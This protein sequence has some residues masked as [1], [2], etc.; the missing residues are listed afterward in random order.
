MTAVRLPFL[1]C[2]Y[3]ECNED[4]GPGIEGET[5]K[6]LRAKAKGA[7]WS[8]ALGA[9]L[10]ATHTANIGAGRGRVRVV[11]ITRNGATDSKVEA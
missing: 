9:D 7:G 1:L 4:Y 2:N 11:S 10:C 8:Q 3:A 6:E 5:V